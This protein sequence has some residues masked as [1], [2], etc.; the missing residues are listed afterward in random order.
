VGLP[1]PVRALAS[2][3]SANILTGLVVNLRR[4]NHVRS[5][6]FFSLTFK[7]VRDKITYDEKIDKEFS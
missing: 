1:A 7:S 6:R 5:S 3:V 2:R 4:R